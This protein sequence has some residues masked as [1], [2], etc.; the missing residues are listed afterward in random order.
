MIP[1]NTARNLILDHLGGERG[2]SQGKSV[3]FPSDELLPGG[4]PP[5]RLRAHGTEFSRISF[6]YTPHLAYAKLLGGATVLGG[7]MR[8]SCTPVLVPQS[9]SQRVLKEGSFCTSAQNRAHHCDQWLL[10][11]LYTKISKMSQGGNRAL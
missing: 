9:P 8:K 10:S 6:I 5:N 2:R 7:T 1:Q 3:R 11:I 4:A